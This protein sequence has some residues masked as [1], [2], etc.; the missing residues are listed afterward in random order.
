MKFRSITAIAVLSLVVASLLVSGCTSST[1]NQTTSETPSMLP[2]YPSVFKPV[3]YLSL[4][5]AGILEQ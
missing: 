3:Y 2:Y 1:T 4:S 5:M